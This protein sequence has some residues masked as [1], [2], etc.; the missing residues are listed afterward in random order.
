M[1]G[2]LS[3]SQLRKPCSRS[4]PVTEV[5][6]LHTMATLPLPPSSSDR[7]SAACAAAAL[8]SVATVVTG[9]SEPGT[10][11]SKAITGMEASA[12]CCRTVAWAWESSE[13]KTSAAGA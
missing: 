4:C 9:M 6:E 12:N 7:C 8:L 5:W 1:S 10:P 2:A 13:A 3:P 11:E